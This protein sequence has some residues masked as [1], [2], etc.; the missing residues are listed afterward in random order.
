MKFIKTIAVL[1]AI[2]SLGAVTVSAKAPKKDKHYTFELNSNVTRTKVFFTNRFGIKL[3]GDLY[4]PK[5][6]DKSAKLAAIAVSGPFGAVKEQSSGLYANQMASK[7]FITLAFDPSFTGESGGEAR[8]ATSSDIST[9]DFSAAVDYL[10]TRNDV[11][12]NKI[13]IIGICGLGGYALNAAALDIRIK[14][15]VTSTMYN[16]NRVESQGYNDAANT[17]ADRKAIKEKLAAARTSDARSK[18]EPQ[19][20]GGVPET[21]PN[22]APQFMKDYHTYYKTN[23]GYQG[24]SVNSTDGFTVSS[25]LSL[26]NTPLLHYSNEIE[27]AALIIHGEN[28]HSRYF[29]EDAYKNMITDSVNPD[30]KELLIIPGANHIDLY[31]NFEKI[32]FDKMEEFFR[33]YLR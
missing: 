29:S 1:A 33:E 21:L 31:D 27:A 19:R 11:D 10:L 23:R 9:E 32:P 15:V 20:T 30:N 24:N 3:A 28:A 12:E 6:A 2:A 8:Y 26:I 7:G 4:A 22:D 16:M 5:N 25:R 14:A 18:L 17:P 13:G